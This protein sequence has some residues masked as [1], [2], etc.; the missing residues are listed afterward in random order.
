MFA[1]EQIKAMNERE[2]NKFHYVC[3]DCGH[4]VNKI[5]K[6]GECPPCVKVTKVLRVV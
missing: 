2:S 3:L 1:L 4:T 5:N 6:D